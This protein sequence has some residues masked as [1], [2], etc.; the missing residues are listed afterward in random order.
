MD[1]DQKRLN[2]SFIGF[3]SDEYC[4]TS[5]SSKSSIKGT[6]LKLRGGLTLISFSHESL[7]SF[8]STSKTP[9]IRDHCPSYDVDG[10]S[11]N[12]DL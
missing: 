10:S 11:P 3:S 9:I 8:P 1:G 12:D 2:W 7:D 6:P 4:V 5:P